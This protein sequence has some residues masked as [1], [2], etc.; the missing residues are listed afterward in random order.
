MGLLTKIAKCVDVLLEDEEP[1]FIAQDTP[2][3]EQHDE[4]YEKGVAFERHV[5]GLF[6]QS[7]FALHDWT[8]DLSG[9]TDGYVIESDANPDVVMRYKPKDTQI[10]IECKF[11]SSLYRGML[12]WTTQKKLLGYRAYMKQTGIATFIVVGLGGSPSAPQRMFC[13][14][15][16]EAEYPQWY[17]STFEKFERP[18]SR[19]FFWNGAT[20]V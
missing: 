3:A 16:T 2:D 7:Y 11:R 5:I 10:A 1:T 8:R 13:V 12:K 18:P 4:N 6:N 9:K 20:L 15:L 19:N 17:S 14:P